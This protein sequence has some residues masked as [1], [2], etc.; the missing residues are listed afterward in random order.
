MCVCVCAQMLFLHTFQPTHFPRIRVSPTKFSYHRSRRKQAHTFDPC[1]TPTHTY[2]H[3]RHDVLST[4]TGSKCPTSSGEWVKTLLTFFLKSLSNISTILSQPL[5]MAQFLVNLDVS[6]VFIKVMKPP[7]ALVLC[8]L[9]CLKENIWG[10]LQSLLR[11]VRS[12]WFD[13]FLSEWRS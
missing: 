12:L 3:C 7:S 4:T 1:V 8:L 10:F 5:R 9:S 13:S 11:P 6:S 2:S